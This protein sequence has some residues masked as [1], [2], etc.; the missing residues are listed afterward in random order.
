MA[1]KIK[2]SRKQIKKPDEFITFTDRVLKQLSEKKNLVIGA[3][4][5]IVL[6]LLLVNLVAYSYRTQRQ[7][8]EYLLAQAFSI[9][10]TPLTEE[11]TVDQI[12]K[13]SKSYATQKERS[14]DA[15]AKFKQVIDKFGKSEPGLEARYHLASLYLE[16]K[17]WENALYYFQE[18]LSALKEHHSQA[19]FN[20]TL[21]AY[22]GMAQAY[23]GKGD[24]EKALE[25]YQKVLDS[26]AETYLAEA[27]LGKAKSLAK[28]GKTQPAQQE[29]EKII[30]LYPDSIYAQLAELELESISEPQ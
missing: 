19:E 27:G 6:L 4:A 15:I 25:Y 30:Q 26:K 13:G 9:L 28:L 24:Y 17:E 10:N 11:L 21:T 14:E 22:L 3:G 16:R 23:Y 1:K 7:K 8:A 5:G 20:L 29:L 2:V 18:F 12:I